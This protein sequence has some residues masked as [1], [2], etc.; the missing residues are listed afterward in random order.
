[1]RVRFLSLSLLAAALLAW[2]AARAQTPE[3]PPGKWWKRPA[4]VQ[5]LALTPEQQEKLDQIFAKGRRDFVD[6]KADVEKKQLDVEELMA[7]KDSDPKKVGAAI[8]AVEQSRA[9]LR[10]ATAMMILEMRGVLTEA[11]WKQVVER[12]EQ[13]RSERRDEMRESMRGGPGPRRPV[14]GGGPPP[15]PAA[16]P[17]DVPKE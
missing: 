4:V 2:G 13:W 1:M 15:P 3:M 9:R 14:E 12:R 11:Q 6:L 5:A 16:R 7:K 8:D 17:S 10:K